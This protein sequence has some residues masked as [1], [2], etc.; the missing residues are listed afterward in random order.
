MAQKPQHTSCCDNN[1]YRHHAKAKAKLKWAS[2]TTAEDAS[3]CVKQ[4]CYTEKATKAHVYQGT[5][6]PRH[7]C[8]K[9]QAH[10]VVNHGRSASL[11]AV[12]EGTG[13]MGGVVPWVVEGRARTWVGWGAG[14]GGGA[15]RRLQS[16][17]GPQCGAMPPASHYGKPRNCATGGAPGCH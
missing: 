6:V 14:G 2:G 1:K 9:A 16:G 5:C 13:G 8:T 3:G 11:R 4:M 12:V 10:V 7:M 15:H 17:R